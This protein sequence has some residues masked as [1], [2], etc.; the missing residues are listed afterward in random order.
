MKNQTGQSRKK[1][2]K[3]PIQWLKSGYL[4]SNVKVTKADGTTYYE[5]PLAENELN[6]V[7]YPYGKK[8]AKKNLQKEE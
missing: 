4:F 7:V 5:N 3:T 8:N 2:E 1:K 6:K